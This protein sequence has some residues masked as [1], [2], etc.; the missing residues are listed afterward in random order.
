MHMERTCG[1][2]MRVDGLCFGGDSRRIAVLRHLD[3]TTHRHHDVK[4]GICFP[5]L[6]LLL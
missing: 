3:S 2:S 1:L 5:T 4:D 6:D